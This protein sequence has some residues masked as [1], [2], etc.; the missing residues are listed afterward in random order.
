LIS[1]EVGECNN[2]SIL[3][4]Y[5]RYQHYVRSESTSTGRIYTSILWLNPDIASKYQMPE[6]IVI[7]SGA[8]KM[9]RDV[10][11]KEK[12]SGNTVMTEHYE[13]E[14]GEGQN[15]GALSKLLAGFFKGQARHIASYK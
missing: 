5:Y 11:Y 2:Y 15:R 6:K 3:D 9:Q 1:K 13:V 4:D 10:F 8:I 14:N 7:K 12:H